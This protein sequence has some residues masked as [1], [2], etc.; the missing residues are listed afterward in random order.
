MRELTMHIK[1]FAVAKEERVSVWEARTGK[2]NSAENRDTIA[3]VLVRGMC[4]FRVENFRGG[5]P[6]SRTTI[7]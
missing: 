6:I 4:L 2:K 1:V 7:P 5:M 3:C